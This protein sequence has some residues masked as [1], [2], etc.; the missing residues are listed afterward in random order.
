MNIDVKILNITK[1]LYW[2]KYKE[3][4]ILRISWSLSQKLKVDLILKKIIDIYY[5]N[6]LRKN[7]L[8]PQ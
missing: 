4:N 6:R 5:I 7:I 3:E 2:T 8:S 1:L